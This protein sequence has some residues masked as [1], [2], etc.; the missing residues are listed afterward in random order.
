MSWKITERTQ[1]LDNTSYTIVAD[2][3][4]D[5]ALIDPAFL[6]CGTSIIVPTIP[7]KVYMVNTQGVPEQIA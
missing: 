7:P 4:S 3:D 5:V 2:Q 6:L 1:G